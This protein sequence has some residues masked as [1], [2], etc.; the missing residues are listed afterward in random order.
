MN[1]NNFDRYVQFLQGGSAINKA[2]KTVKKEAKNSTENTVKR[3]AKTGT[4]KRTVKKP[5]TS[6]RSVSTTNAGYK[7]LSGREER[8]ALLKRAEELNIKNYR[9]TNTGVLR[10][11]VMEADA[12]AATSTKPVSTPTPKSTP[13]QQS[14][15]DTP[16]ETSTTLSAVEAMPATSTNVE[17]ISTFKTPKSEQVEQAAKNT[18]P[19]NNNSITDQVAPS[20]SE[21]QSFYR[22]IR[23]KWNGLSQDK[24]NELKSLGIGVSPIIPIGIAMGILG[25]NIY[26]ENQ[27]NNYPETTASDSISLEPDNVQVVP[28]DSVPLPIT[29][30]VVVAAPAVGSMPDSVVVQPVQS[31]Q[32]QYVST[33]TQVST[34]AVQ[35][36]QET[37][38][39]QPKTSR[40][41]QI[42]RNPQQEDVR[43]NVDSLVESVV[44]P[45]EV[46]QYSQEVLQN[47]PTQSDQ[48]VVISNT[49][50]KTVSIPV[51]ESSNIYNTIPE[52][53]IRQIE[54]SVQRN[55]VNKKPVVLIKKN[56]SVPINLQDYNGYVDIPEETS[57]YTEPI[58]AEVAYNIRTN[59]VEDQRLRKEYLKQEIA[60][61]ARAL[62]EQ[63]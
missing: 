7:G 53:T 49:P 36:Q 54:D 43:Y 39:K 37:V 51:V 59:Y 4:K 56:K 19:V 40:N 26:N 48:A 58:P 46:P 21:N 61:I 11:K 42:Q 18:T 9:K 24:K 22:R 16:I 30:S 52:A 27:Q 6:Q 60:N 28:V 34:K 33:P 23:E 29:D 41:R 14:L 20:A 44:V 32:P 5:I 62:N 10:K 57:V 50:T 45:Q 3:E 31:V 8:A 47:V 15:F 12:K 55:V 13:V 63:L 2:V 1:T 35:P 38:S 25:H 17:T